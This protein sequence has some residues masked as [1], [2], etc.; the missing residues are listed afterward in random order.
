MVHLHKLGG[1]EPK[2]WAKIDGS[3]SGIAFSPDGK[4]LATGCPDT[5]V[6]IWD[7]TGD[8]AEENTA[9]RAQESAVLASLFAERESSGQPLHSILM[10]LWKFD[11][12]APESGALVNEDGPAART[13]SI[14]FSHN[15]NSSSPAATLARRRCAS[16]TP[17]AVSLFAREVAA[18]HPRAR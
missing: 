15:G 12:V 11:D 7:L 17:R 10:R 13:S 5:R 3:P 16:G 14:A 1:K 8:E 9:G 18:A 6:V 4:W 2:S